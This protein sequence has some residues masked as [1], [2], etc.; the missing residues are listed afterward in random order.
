MVQLFHG[1]RQGGDDRRH[2]DHAAEHGRARGEPGALELARHLIAHDVGLLEHLLRQRIVG[3]RRR[4]VDEDRQRRLQRMRE[5]ADMGAGALDDLAVGVDQRVGLARQRGDLDRKL[6]LEPL[7]V[8][9]ADRRKAFRDALER[10]QAEAHLQRGGQQQRRRQRRE[11]RA[12]DAVEAQHLV[13]D[14]GGVAGDGDEVAAVVAEIDV[15]LD[16]AQPLVLRALGVAL[17]RTPPGAASPAF[18]AGAADWNPTAS[19]RNALPSR[20]CRAA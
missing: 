2:L 8:A 16:D 13:V 12:D 6:A 5:I 19:A 3:A 9:G 4:L 7:G 1:A 14:L 18:P 17:A 10:Q 15:A 11:D 20:R